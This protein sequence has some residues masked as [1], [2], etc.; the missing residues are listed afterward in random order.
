MSEKKFLLD[1]VNNFIAKKYCQED[2]ESVVNLKQFLLE[3]EDDELY[4][5][6]RLAKV[7]LNETNCGNYEVIQKAL[8]SN[9]LKFVSQL[10]LENYDHGNDD[11]IEILTGDLSDDEKYIIIADALYLFNDKEFN[12]LIII[13]KKVS[14]KMSES[15]LRSLNLIYSKLS[16]AGAI[17]EILNI[18]NIDI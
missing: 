4:I 2:K 13:N 8:G 6:N 5:L 9:I 15:I 3:N 16:F 18:F 10:I 11:L 1:T 17:D 12:N 14:Q 7:R